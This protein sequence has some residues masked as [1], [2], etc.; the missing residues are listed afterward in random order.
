MTHSRLVLHRSGN[1]Y[2]LNELS[3]THIR[4]SFGDLQPG[5][6]TC[7]NHQFPIA[8]NGLAAIVDTGFAIL[9][10]QKTTLL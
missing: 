10:I 3:A 8:W 4:T 2:G 6:T 5:F 7:D 1:P 9:L